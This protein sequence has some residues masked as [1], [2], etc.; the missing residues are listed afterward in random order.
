[1]TTWTQDEKMV[2]YFTPPPPPTNNV[3]VTSYLQVTI[4]FTSEN[5]Y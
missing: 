5:W 3:L 2:S 4:Y 1:M